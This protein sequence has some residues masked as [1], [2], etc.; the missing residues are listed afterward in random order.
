VPIAS[1]R[2]LLVLALLPLAA[3]GLWSSPGRGRRG[4][5]GAEAEIPRVEDSLLATKLREALAEADGLAGASITPHVY[6]G[7]VFLVGFVTTSA[8][9]DT[10]TEAARDVE[11]VRSVNGYLPIR[12]GADV[13]RA[14]APDDAAIEAKVKAELARSGQPVARVD[15]DVLD[16]HV[17]L[18]GVVSS[19][20]A[21]AAVSAAARRVSGVKGVT[22]FLLLPEPD[23]ER[24]PPGLG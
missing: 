8:Q 12:A 7:H 21:A 22:S 11:G 13:A 2:L 1:R 4:G 19:Q 17:V 3:C 15:M 6:M 16:G 10:A 20:E 5:G 24:P 14:D 18:L 23:Y 9:H